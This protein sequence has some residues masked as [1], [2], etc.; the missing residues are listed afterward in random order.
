MKNNIVIIIPLHE[1]NDEMQPL[2]Q[3]AL[4]SVPSEYEVRLSCAKGVKELLP[5]DLIQDNVKVIETQSDS[6]KF[7]HLVNQAIENS[8]WFSILE[9]DD[10]Y[11]AVWFNNIN[12]Y[13]EYFSDISVFLPI[14]EVYDFNKNQMISFGNEAPWASAFSNELGYIDN[15]VLNDFYDFFM[16][17]GLFKTSDWQ[18]INGL[19]ESFE[20]SFWLEYLLRAT[21][22]GQKIYVIPKIGYKH[23]INRPKSLFEEYRIN[24]PQEEK[25][26][27]IDLAKEEYVNLTDRKITYNK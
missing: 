10:E 18:K 2:L 14:N 3:R 16:T 19:K 20:L 5:Q 24:M 23:Y 13:I 4:N 17:G 21:S 7:S 8:D 9:Y 15:N 6:K 12:K 1:W 26:W 25:Q 27:W 22:Q 11:N